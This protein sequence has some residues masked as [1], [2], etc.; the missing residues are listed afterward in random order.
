VRLS[1]CHGNGLIAILG[2]LCGLLVNSRESSGES[3]FDLMYY[4]RKLACWYWMFFG[5][6]VKTQTGNKL[7]ESSFFALLCCVRLLIMAVCL[8]L[9][10][11]M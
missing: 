2:D 9:E 5:S 4:H 8:I 7:I 10:Q 6:A 11:G 1:C 3:W